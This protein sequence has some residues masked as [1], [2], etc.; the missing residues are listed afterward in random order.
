MRILHTA[1][2]HLGRQLH[3]VSLIE[4]QACA[5]EQFFDAIRQYKPD[6]VIVAGDIFD[7]ALPPVEAV[8]LFDETLS[9]LRSDYQGPVIFIAGNHDSPERIDYGSRLFESNGIYIRG[10][11]TKAPAVVKLDD[12][13]GKVDLVLIPYL[14]APVARQILGDDAI[15][16]QE[17]A[18][19]AACYEALKVSRAGARRVAVAH[20]FVDGGK[21]SESE[22][23]LLVGGSGRV[24]AAVFDDYSYVA[25][26]HLHEPQQISRPGVRYSGSLCKY[27]FSEAS[28]QKS[29]SLVDLAADGGV[30]IEEFP[31]SYRRD[32]RRLRG[33]FAELMKGEGGGLEDYILA[34]IT[35]TGAIIDAMNQLR[36]VYPNILQIRRINLE[37]MI[38]SAAS[39]RMDLKTTPLEMFSRFLKH[40]T[41]DEAE[42]AHLSAFEKAIGDQSLREREVIEDEAAAN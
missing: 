10:S 42:A 22:R 30:T 35:D 11:F 9:R 29:F 27:S 2:W 3:G 5:L 24:P 14:E 12:K 38:D 20:A 40:V 6:C 21:E 13:H 25:L 31:L 39:E 1:D 7:R 17:E 26:G 18:I 32:V 16:T 4:D 8:R 28:H 36:A 34:E 23:P 19:K 37:R 33:S 15:Q 41:G